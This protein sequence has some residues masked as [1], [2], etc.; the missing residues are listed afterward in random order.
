MAPDDPA[1]NSEPLHLLIAG[2]AHEL[3]TPLG[4]IH[5]NN[6]TLSRA[7]DK[8]KD[9]LVQDGFSGQ[10]E[11]RQATAR[12]IDILQDVSANTSLATERLIGIVS[13]LKT[14]AHLDEAEL[15]KADIHEGIESTLTIIQH[16]L[17]DRITVVKEFGELPL[18]ECYAGRMNQVFLNLLVNAAQAIPDRGTIVIRT[19]RAGDSVRISVSDNGVGI[20]PENLAKIFS[21]GFTTKGVGVGT[22]LGLSICYRIVQEHHG[23]IDVKSGGG[24]TT[25]TIDLPLR[26]RKK[27]KRG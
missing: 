19:S 23:T 25:F 4:A 9:L 3:N 7:I 20:P 22:G 24:Q 18:V 21:P 16:Q 26:Q 13:S 27:V 17:R 8:L 15:K 14:F 5:S 2:L 10:A 6:D 11:N 1:L 12:L